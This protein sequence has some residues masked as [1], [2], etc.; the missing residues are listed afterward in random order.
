MPLQPSLP[1]GLQLAAANG[2]KMAAAV[3]VMAM[4]SFICVQERVHTSGRNSNVRR[5]DDTRV[6][7]EKE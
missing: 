4:L 1:S 3:A 7:V 6:E 5:A 2:T